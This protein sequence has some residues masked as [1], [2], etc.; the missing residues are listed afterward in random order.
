MNPVL[1][2]IYGTGHAKTASAAEEDLDLNNISAA[3]LLEML[4]QQEEPEKTAGE[5]E[6]DLSKMSA[7][8]LVELM[9]QADELEA[10][11]SEKVALEKMASDGSLDYFDLAGRVMA[12]AYVNELDKVAS[13]SNDDTIE[14]DLDTMTGAE[15]ASLME[16][17]YQFVEPEAAV[18]PSEDAT[19]EAAVK[20][21]M[22]R[23]GK[24]AK[25]PVATYQKSL[26]A[27]GQQAAAG[28][29]AARGAIGQRLKA[30]RTAAEKNKGQAAAAAG[31]S[32]A[33]VGATAAGAEGIRRMMRKD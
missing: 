2:S 28:H 32:A 19:K 7:R 8:E 26:R 3:Q 20:D 13:Q 30:L 10:Q 22:E 21:L 4:A 12:H 1:A 14:V 6:I 9:E 11:E 5:G 16:Q 17:G 31:I 27:Q 24:W 33:G 18:E 15:L 23:L 25:K 29:P